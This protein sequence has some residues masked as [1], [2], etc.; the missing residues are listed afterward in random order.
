MQCEVLTRSRGSRRSWRRSTAV[1][2]MNPRLEVGGHRA[3]DVRSSRNN[4]AHQVAEEVRRHFR[5]FDSVIPAQRAPQ[6]ST[7]ARQA[8]A[9]LRRAV[10]GRA[11]VPV[12]RARAPL[13]R[14]GRQ[15]PRRREWWR[16]ASGHVSAPEDEAARPRSRPRRAAARRAIAELRRQERLR[17]PG[18]EDSSRRRRQPRQRFDTAKLEELAQSIR[19]HGLIEPLVGPPHPRGPTGS[20]SSPASVAGAPSSGAGVRRS[21]RRS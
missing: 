8:G 14:V 16:E 12:A 2:T 4:L 13:E 17:L 3:H 15:R 19:E 20:S 6:R 5:V 1:R 9:A 11:G 10:E 18:R 7:L 21:A